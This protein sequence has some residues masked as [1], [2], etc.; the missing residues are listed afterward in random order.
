MSLSQGNNKKITI[1]HVLFRLPYFLTIRAMIEICDPIKCDLHQP[2]F[3]MKPR[4]A[5][6]GGVITGWKFWNV[7][8]RKPC[9]HFPK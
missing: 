9:C 4:V 7:S 5:V 3:H 6:A 8:R 2:A 1:I